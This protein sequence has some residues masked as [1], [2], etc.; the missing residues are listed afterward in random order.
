MILDTTITQEIV[1]TLD[2]LADELLVTGDHDANAGTPNTTQIQLTSDTAFFDRLRV[3]GIGQQ[4]IGNSG[5][6]QFRLTG[7]ESTNFPMAP[8][9]KIYWFGT[10]TTDDVASTTSLSILVSTLIE[11]KTSTL[12]P[13]AALLLGCA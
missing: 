9:G 12:E 10:V 8:D 11:T 5:D 4:T 3:L 1:E 13:K 2:D 7:D 6:A